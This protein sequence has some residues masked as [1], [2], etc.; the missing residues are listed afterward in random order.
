[1]PSLYTDEERKQRGRD[2]AK[3]YRDKNPEKNRERVANWRANN[4][5]W[6]AQYFKSDSFKLSNQK[7][8]DKNKEKY[9]ESRQKWEENNREKRR[10]QRAEAYKKNPQK[11]RDKALAHLNKPGV[12]E[13]VAI[14]AKKSKDNPA[15]RDRLVVNKQN[16]RALLQEVGGVLSA[17][18]AAKLL[19]LQLCSCASCKCDLS[20][21]GH[22]L[23]HIMP[24]ALNGQNIDSNIQLLCPDCNRKK[25]AKD[26]IEWA[27]QNGRLL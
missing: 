24:L 16:R 3:R 21:S 26:P 23:D 15:V 27:Q 14:Y 13:K 1:M 25:N 9:A 5:E 20:K 4:P 17:N 8:A 12:R 2:A 7:S 10:Q 18:L 11:Y 22:H 19:K 6:V